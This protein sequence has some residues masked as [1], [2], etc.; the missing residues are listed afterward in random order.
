[1][2]RSALLVFLVFSPLTTAAQHGHSHDG[3][4][5]ISFPDTAEYLSLTCDLHMHT[6]FSDG[7]V[8]PTVRVQEAQRDGID[9]IAITEHLEYQPHRADIPHPDR[10]RAFDIATRSAEGSDL[11]VIRGSEITRSLPY[12]HANSIF[13]SDANP[14]LQEDAED[15][16]EAA[17]AQGGFTFINH[18]NWTAQRKDG[19]AR[20]EPEQMSLIERGLIHGI[21]VVNDLTYSDEAIAL[22]L[23]HDLTIIGTSD[24]HGLV[25]WQYDIAGG[26]HRPVTI[27]FATERSEAAIREAL[28]EGRTVAY[29]LDSII[30]REAHLRPLIE[31]SLKVTSS[32]YLGDTS[33]ARVSIQNTSDAWFTLRNVS[34]FRFQDRANLV[35]VPPHH[36]I[37]LE[38]KTGDRMPSLD[39][40]FEVLNA[41]TAPETHPVFSVSVPLPQ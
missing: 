3:G 17:G 15:A 7:D 12:G 30:G 35:D 37:T 21:E 28:F 14:L 2:L 33:V 16:Y 41:I 10:N 36:T 8:W 25:D 6:V 23:E 39:L 40:S 32:G 26:G 34:A 11:I 38:V 27:V 19:V 1:M 4:R 22:A 18:P 9:C 31:A 13:L 20:L 29:Y 5:V 24:I